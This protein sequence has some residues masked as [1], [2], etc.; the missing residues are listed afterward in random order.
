MRSSPQA[1]RATFA[2]RGTAL[3]H[4]LPVALTPSFAEDATKKI[5]WLAFTKKSGTREAGSLAEVV[6]RI[7][8]FAEEPLRAAASSMRFPLQWRSGGPWT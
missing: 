5:Q 7:V 6:A 2:R 3:P 8:T 1:I 4:E